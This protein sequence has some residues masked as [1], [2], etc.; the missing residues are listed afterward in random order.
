ME[1]SVTREHQCTVIHLKEEKLE[2]FA[3][4]LQNIANDLNL[5]IKDFEYRSNKV[6]FTLCGEMLAIEK[7]LGDFAEQWSVREMGVSEFARTMD[8]S[9]D[10]AKEWYDSIVKYQSVIMSKSAFESQIV[11]KFGRMTDIKK[12]KY[13]KK[14]FMDNLEELIQNRIDSIEGKEDD[15]SLFFQRQAEKQELLTVLEKSDGNLDQKTLDIVM[16]FIQKSQ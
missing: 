6:L 10:E 2:F 13:L 1:G 3:K 11:A 7:F 12:L 4:E 9:D 5:Q 15:F 8:I 16:S 14:H